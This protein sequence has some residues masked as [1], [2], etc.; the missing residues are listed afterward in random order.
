MKLKIMQYNTYSCS[1]YKD[2]KVDFKGT[3]EAIAKFDP[4]IIGLN[5]IRDEGASVEYDAQLRILSSMLGFSYFYFAKAI[6][7]NG[8]NPYGN[9]LMSKYPIIEADTVM[10][11]DP[12]VRKYDGYYETRCVLKA[13][14]LVDGKILNVVVS[15]FGLNPDEAE[16]AVKTV[17]ENLESENCILMGDFNVTPEDKVL[18]PIR[19][20][21]VDTAIFFEGE[22]LSFPSYAPERKID[23]ILTTPDI[24]VLK[25]DIPEIIAS[26]HRP[27]TLE[28]EF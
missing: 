15:H 4:D 9:G 24:N 25:A 23:Y 21:L 5:E 18:E 19:E 7:D 11:P 28:I 14:I 12:K 8:P 2:A 13:K 1:N 22:R 20:R 17:A 3:A 27:H 6:D 10:I 16:N 26:D